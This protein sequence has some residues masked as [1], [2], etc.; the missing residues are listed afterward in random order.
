MPSTASQFKTIRVRGMTYR[1]LQRIKSA[2]RWSFAE[3]A[4]VLA[5]VEL[6]KIESEKAAKDSAA[7]V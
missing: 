1:K 7:V 4:D 6:S 5:D 2:R 3:I